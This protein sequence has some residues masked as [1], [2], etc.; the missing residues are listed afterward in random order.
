MQ[1][2]INF[3]FLSC[4]K[5]A[6]LMEKKIH[7]QLNIKE[8]FQLHMHTKV[9]ETCK[10]WEK[11]SQELE[12]TLHNHLS[13]KELSFPSDIEISETFKKKLMNRFK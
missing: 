2:L 13:Q 8:T 4:T 1:T 10:K 5:A 6:E 3:L 9:C 7:F 12:H 11:Q